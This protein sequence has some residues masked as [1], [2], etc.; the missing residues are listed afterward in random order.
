MSLSALATA[1]TALAFA[2]AL[3]VI[4]G[5]TACARPDAPVA[6]APAPA[7]VVDVSSSSTSSASASASS[8]VSASAAGVVPSAG[9][10]PAPAVQGRGAVRLGNQHPLGPAALAFAKYLNA[11]HNRIHGPFTDDALQK[12][13]A[14]RPNDAL[15]DMS[16]MTR[17]EL[18]IDGKTGDVVKQTVVR[19][20]G[21]S[22]FDELGMEAVRRAA[23]FGPAD[24]PLWSSDGNVYVHWEFRRDPVFGC[25]TMHARPFLLDI[26]SAPQRTP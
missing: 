20:S 10:A 6:S 14:L 8:S 19:T 16:L 24:A 12:L 11:M 13:D 26:W 21:I 23:P 18:M 1:A 5:T 15:N 25:S 2:C 22:A 7:I 9:P 4:G 17:V 3:A